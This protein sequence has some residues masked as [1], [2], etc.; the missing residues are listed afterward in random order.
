MLNSYG[1]YYKQ[2][3]VRGWTFPH[4]LCL[5]MAYLVIALPFY[6]SFSDTSTFHPIPRVLALS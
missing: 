3:L 4:L 2:Y 1:D 5:F 6:L